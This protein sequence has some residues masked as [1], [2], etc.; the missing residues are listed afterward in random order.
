MQYAI[1]TNTTRT[2]CIAILTLIAALL[3]P[4]PRAQAVVLDKY[5]IVTAYATSQL[6]VSYVANAS[7]PGAGFDCSGFTKWVMSTIGVKLTHYSAAQWNEGMAAWGLKDTTQLKRGDLIFFTE[8]TNPGLT[9]KT[10]PSSGIN[11]VGIFL[12]GSGADKYLYIH[13]AEGI[14]V[15]FKRLD[16]GGT[17]ADRYYGHKRYF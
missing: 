5:A 12:G 1:R 4:A 7:S 16:D 8:K 2:L 6:G 17:L 14:G 15:S 10:N 9:E 13:S 3:I 11:H